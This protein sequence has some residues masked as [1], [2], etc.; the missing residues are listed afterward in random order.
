M[1]R[2]SLYGRIA[3]LTL[4][5][6][7]AVAA[8]SRAANLDLTAGG[9]LIYEATQAMGVFND[10]THRARER[11]VRDPRPGRTRDRPIPERARRGL[12]LLQQSDS[13]LPGCLDRVSRR[14]YEGGQRPH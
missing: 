8:P 1:K 5:G 13:H 6:L 3:A 2:R 12:R 11:H 10:L 7:A 4:F 14:G 9:Q